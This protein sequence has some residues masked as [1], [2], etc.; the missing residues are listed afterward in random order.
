MNIIHA[1][2]IPSAHHHNASNH[3]KTLIKTALT[4]GQH[5]LLTAP[6][7]SPR[8]TSSD[9]QKL[10]TSAKHPD[11]ILIDIPTARS[12]DSQNPLKLE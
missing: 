12:P 5:T 6:T 9:I 10:Q 1:R 3:Q 2:K 8:C 4:S 11:C 7:L